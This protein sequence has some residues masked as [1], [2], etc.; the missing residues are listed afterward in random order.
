MNLGELHTLV[1]ASLRRGTALDAHIP[2]AV[3]RAARW[4]ERNYSLKYMEE[5][6]LFDIDASATNPRLI[7]LPSAVKKIEFFRW[8]DTDGDYHNMTQVAAQDFPDN[9]E[10]DPVSFWMEGDRRL[11]LGETPEDDIDGAEILFI[12]YTSWPTDDAAEHWLI[13][14]AEDLLLAQSAMNMLPFTR[15]YDS[16]PLWKNARDEAVRTLLIADEELRQSIGQVA[17]DPN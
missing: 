10:T 17:M 14:N 7:T 3:R 9:E 5:H 12:R 8:K 1:S 2:G 11:Y 16:A 13:D 15:D 6:F 4:I